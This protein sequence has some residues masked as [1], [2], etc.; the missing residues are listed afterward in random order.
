MQ[1]TVTERSRRRRRFPAGRLFDCVLIF[2]DR[3]AVL[4]K[5]AHQRLANLGG[6]AVAEVE[7]APNYKGH[8]RNRFLIRGFVKPEW[9]SVRALRILCPSCNLVVRHGAKTGRRVDAA[10]LG[11]RHHVA[12]EGESLAEDDVG[13]RASEHASTV[14]SRIAFPNE[15]RTYAESSVEILRGLYHAPNKGNYP[16]KVAGRLRR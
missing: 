8:T 16:V 3:C 15:R 11:T 4:L 2:L 10:A 5:T 9:H 6:E 7:D 12:L 14:R 1:N 13:R